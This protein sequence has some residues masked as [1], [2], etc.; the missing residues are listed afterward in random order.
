MLRNMRRLNWTSGVPRI[1]LKDPW[2]DLAFL[3]Q[4]F[5]TCEGRFSLIFLYHI[6]LLMHL[7]GEKP[8]N[9]PYYFLNILTKMAKSIQ[10][11]TKNVERSLYHHGLI[12][13]VV[14]HELS[15]KGIGWSEFLA[16]NGFEDDDK[17]TE[18]HASRNISQETTRHQELVDQPRKKKKK[19]KV[20]KDT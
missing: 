15:K 1:W 17:G 8:L 2:K 3:I 11:Q 6:K 12:K 19:K 14:K 16:S 20:S 10:R 7:K 4:K 18:E 9:I 13:L 5:I